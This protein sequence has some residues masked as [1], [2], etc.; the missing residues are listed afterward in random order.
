M[1]SKI[2][3]GK[4]KKSWDVHLFRI[5]WKCLERMWK[6][7]RKLL[8]I[9]KVITDEKAMNCNVNEQTHWFCEFIGFLRDSER[10]PK[11]VRGVRGS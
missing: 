4:R 3:V 1:L 10:D 7:S 11:G 9:S 2:E 8:D 5:H 6:T